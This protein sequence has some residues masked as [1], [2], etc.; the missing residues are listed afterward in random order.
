VITAILCTLFP[1]LPLRIL[2]PRTYWH[3]AWLV[4]WF[5][6]GMVPLALSYVLVNNLLAQTR[7]GVVPAVVVLAVAYGVTLTLRHETFLQ[8]VQTFCF[9]SALQFGTCLGFTWYSHKRK[10]SNGLNA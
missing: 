2:S 5:A 1:E 6:W 9:F 8:I 4:P 10:A 3:A 7:Y